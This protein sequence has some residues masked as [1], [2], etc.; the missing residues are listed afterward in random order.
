MTLF[1]YTYATM[2]EQKK[3]EE[4]E[5]D[6]LHPDD[7]VAA[8]DISTESADSLEAAEELDDFSGPDARPEHTIAA[9]PQHTTE[10]S[11]YT[12]TYFACAGVIA[13]LLIDYVVRL[14]GAEFFWTLRLMYFTS[15]IIRFFVLLAIIHFNR[16]NFFKDTPTLYVVTAVMGFAAGLILALDRFVENA[17]VWTFFN[18]LTEPIDSTL[19]ALAVAYI[20]HHLS[21][22]ALSLNKKNI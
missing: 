12:W 20:V 6:V 16:A 19:I 3:F 14:I 13:L 9:T 18:I 17:S 10:K 15:F 2:E 5:G 21:S 1:C 4:N 11:T 8:E 22:N 7:T